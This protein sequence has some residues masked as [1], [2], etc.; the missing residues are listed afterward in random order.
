MNRS[1]WLTNI[2]S[3]WT[4]LREND[5]FRHRIPLPQSN[6]DAAK[7]MRVA[8]ILGTF[9]KLVDKIIFQP[10]FL[11]REYSGL[12]EVL[13]HQAVLDPGKERY[14]RGI[15]LSM[16]PEDQDTICTE[17]VDIVVEE[18]L[19]TVNVRALLTAETAPA[20]EKALASLVA[21]FQEAWKVIQRGKQKLEPS[22]KYSPS[23]DF[24]WLVLDIHR[25]EVEAGKHNEVQPPTGNLDDDLVIVPRVYL[26]VTGPGTEPTPVTHGLVVRK[27]HLLAAE[28]EARESLSGAPFARAPSSRHRSR[29]VRGMSVT[30]DAGL[31][32]RGGNHFLSQARGGPGS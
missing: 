31:S 9:A 19:D 18:L 22:F 20:F 17:G 27:A 7:E 11:L 29:P 14:A 5:I 28:E 26:M 1:A 2:Q 6:S 30:N 16:F 25:A 15:L 8:V 4:K 13:R 12:R 10:T 24:H 3:D 21:Q 23:I 32:G